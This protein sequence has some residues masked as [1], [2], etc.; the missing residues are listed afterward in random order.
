MKSILAAA[1][2]IVAALGFGSATA[3][4]QPTAGHR[5][6]S[7]SV[8]NDLGW[9]SGATGTGTVSPSDLGWGGGTTPLPA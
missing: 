5:Q 1:A 7:A 4:H 8:A 6:F 9:G 3:A 2:L